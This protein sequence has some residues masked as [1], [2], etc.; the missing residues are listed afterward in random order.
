MDNSIK[1]ALDSGHGIAVVYAAA[2]GLLASDLIPTPADAFYFYRQQKLKKDLQSGRITPKKYWYQEAIGY[3]TYNA[4]WWLIVLAAVYFTKG[5]YTNK[6]KVGVS[7]IAAGAVIAV[8]HRN[9]KADE[10]NG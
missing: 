4:A 5:T 10:A 6:I 1:K 7:L 8:I 2:I 9:I 3:Y